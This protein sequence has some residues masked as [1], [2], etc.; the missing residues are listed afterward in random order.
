MQYGTNV[1]LWKRLLDVLSVG[2][3]Y[4]LAW[5]WSQVLGLAFSVSPWPWPWMPWPWP[6][7][8]SPWKHHRFPLHSYFRLGQVP[9]KNHWDCCRCLTGRTALL[10]PN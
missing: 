6:W 2:H 1:S 4:F 7:T 8:Q 10:T 9:R 5:P 3:E